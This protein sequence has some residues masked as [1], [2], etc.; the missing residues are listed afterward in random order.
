MY[1]LLP[2]LGISMTNTYHLGFSVTMVRYIN[3]KDLPRIIL[4]YGWH[5]NDRYNHVFSD[6]IGRY[7]NGKE[8][9]SCVL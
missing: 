7:I 6:T 8:L 1:Y 4:R 9:P 3:D 2:W 5:V